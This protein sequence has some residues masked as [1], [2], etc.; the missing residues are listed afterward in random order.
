MGVVHRARD[1][2]SGR[3]VALKVLLDPAQRA[4]VERF[5]REGKITAALRHPGIVRIH[6]TGAVDGCPYLAYELVEGA[7]T[8]DEVLPLLERTRRLELVRDVARALGHAHAHG[9]VHR[10]VKPSNVL[11]GRDGRARVADFGLAI[12]D[13]SALDRLT[14]TG[15]MVGTP[16][17]MSPEQFAGK[18]DQVGPASDVWSL[19]V[20]LYLA[21]TNELP[22]MAPT[23]LQ[24]GAA[25]TT[26]RP[27]RPT[28]LDPTIAKDL[29]AI[30][31][32]ALQRDPRDRYPDGERL[33]QDLDR[34]LRGEPALA[35]RADAPS[36]EWRR[37]AR[38]LPWVAAPAAGLALFVAALLIVTRLGD[39]APATTTTAGAGD[40]RPPTLTLHTPAPGASTPQEKVAL[41]ATVRDEV[42]PAVQVVVA[43]GAERREVLVER[44]R[45]LEL[46]LPLEIG[47]NLVRVTA[48]DGAGNAV[49]AEVTVTR[50]WTGPPFPRSL[51]PLRQGEFLNPTDGSILVWAPP[52]EFLMG[53]VSDS[54]D[55]LPVHQVELARGVFV[56]KHEVTWAQFARFCEATGLELPSPVITHMGAFKA[57]LD[58]PVFN[59]TWEEAAAYC[60]WAGLRLPTEAEWEYAARGTDN[61]SVPWGA[62]QKVGRLPPANCGRYSS[63]RSEGDGREPAD[64]HLYTSPVD[65]FPRGASPFGC[66]NMAGNVWEW[67]G[68]WYTPEYDVARQVDPTGAPTGKEGVARGGSW[69]Y[70]A[71]L[72]RSTNRRALDPGARRDDVGFRVAC[73]PA[74]GG[75]PEATPAPGWSALASATQAPARGYVAM[76]HD[77]ARAETLWFGGYD[78][79]ERRNDTWVHD[80]RGWRMRDPAT[81]P[82]GR[83]DHTLVYDPQRRYVLL[84]GGTD[85]RAPLGDAWTWDGVDWRASPAGPP[86]RNHHAMVACPDRGVALLFG[87]QSGTEVLGDTWEWDGTRWT[88]SLGR[89]PSPRRG[90]RL[91][92]DGARRVA[93]LFGGEGVD[94][95]RDETWLWDGAQWR[96]APAAEPRP[97]PR[98]DHAL[99]FDPVRGAVILF[100]GHDGRRHLD[101]TWA[102]DGARWVELELGPRPPARKT[103]GLVHEPARGRLVLFGGVQRLRAA[104][105]LVS[106]ITSGYLADAWTLDA[107]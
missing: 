52:G 61:R 96:E 85:G 49:A 42:S 31:M 77:E 36:V 39:P 81:R 98:R 88:Q 12:D 73:S 89:G 76:A 78:G 18:R 62:D 72:A 17:T 43:C 21:L 19:G 97:C 90:H 14:K 87:G 51:R 83:A 44:G 53:G 35:R 101:D 29:E 65:A 41:R 57:G 68:D 69:F 24:L 94:T 95:L 56:G 74:G 47:E 45:T 11:V 32:I 102:W 105:D 22:F 71:S 37:L 9:V 93:V 3:E 63:T 25:I 54:E 75:P 99:A 67:V 59:V 6:S 1:V 107:R 58:H 30:C 50:T 38:A 91:A 64:G 82:P 23:L 2:V 20:L 28:L 103:H 46:E 5:E 13:E 66:L 86:A 55:E 40:A 70:A 104:R 33:A 79:R 92:W 100:G 34:Y 26:A 80:G 15:V 27:R 4:R 16:L 84:F 8:L 60:R 106:G 10:D 7:R 48:T